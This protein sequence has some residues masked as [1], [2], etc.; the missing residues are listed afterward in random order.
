M[1]NSAFV[2]A[3]F[4]LTW[5]VVLGYVVH[6]SRAM[7]RSRDLLDRATRSPAR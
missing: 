7:R 5:A 4:A 3:A 6:L 2:I 1:S